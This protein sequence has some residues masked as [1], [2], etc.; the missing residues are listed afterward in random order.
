MSTPSMSKTTARI[1]FCIVDSGLSISLGPRK[2][3]PFSLR[4]LVV[5]GGPDIDYE[6]GDGVC[7]HAPNQLRQ[8]VKSDVRARFVGNSVKQ[9]WR[10]N[11]D[12]A[13]GPM[14]L[15]LGR[16]FGELGNHV[17]LIGTHDAAPPRVFHRVDAERGG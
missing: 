11:H 17:V 6:F 10:S 9:S 13:E 3:R 12:S 4:F 2:S 14:T 15:R 5:F 7:S 1:P 8:H 16:L